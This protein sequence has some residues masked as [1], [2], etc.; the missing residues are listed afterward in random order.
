MSYLTIIVASY[1]LIHIGY[2]L[3]ERFERFNEFEDGDYGCLN[4]IFQPHCVATYS[5]VGVYV[6]D[7]IFTCFLI[8]GASKVCKQSIS[9]SNILALDAHLFKLKTFPVFCWLVLSFYHL[10]DFLLL[11]TPFYGEPL[12][13]R[14]VPTLMW[15]DFG[16]TKQIKLL[17][18]SF[19]LLS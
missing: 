1:D 6:L 9:H 16:N 2:E 8:Y 3:K 10:V 17:K 12:L 19:K 11:F 5:E 7:L 14:N 15:P 18:K 13:V 4:R